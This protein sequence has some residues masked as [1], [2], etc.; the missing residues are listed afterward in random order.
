MRVI[1]DT[2]VFISGVFFSGPPYVILDAWRHNALSLVIS[3]EILAEYRETGEVLS[4]QFANIDLEPWLGLVTLKASMVKA[5]PLAEAVCS[6]PDDDK[7][8]AC[9]L[10]GGI[11]FVIT[12]D[13]ALLKTS[14]YC[15]IQVVRPREFVEQHLKRS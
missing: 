1:L 4:R 13:L 12:G 3:P 5:T 11:R 9:A 8:L 14:G 15:G 10:A 6:D 2:N 7:F